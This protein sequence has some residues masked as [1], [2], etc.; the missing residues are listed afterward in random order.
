MLIT[1]QTS[2][3]VP[4][5]TVPVLLIT[6]PRLGAVQSVPLLAWKTADQPAGSV[7]LLPK[8]VVDEASRSYESA[9]L[10][11]LVL[12]TYRV[13]VV[14]V[15]GLV[16]LFTTAEASGPAPE[17]NTPG[18]PRAALLVTSTVLVVMATKRS[19]MLALAPA[20]NAP[21]TVDVAVAVAL[22][23][24]P[25]APAGKPAFTITV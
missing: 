16:A 3:A 23:G 22:N 15:P 12:L 8:V 5:F 14:V 24:P 13:K 4:P 17:P 1:A 7:L 6:A 19:V 11:P 9:T 10:A 18:W 25:V 2:F 21:T 20:F